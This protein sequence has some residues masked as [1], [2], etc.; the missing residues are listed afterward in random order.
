M[1]FQSNNSLVGL[2]NERD[3]DIL[4][5][6]VGRTVEAHA[7]L[8][9]A[10]EVL[11]VERASAV[12]AGP[13]L[14]ICH[15]EIGDAFE[16]RRLRRFAADVGGNAVFSSICEGDLASALVDALDTFGEACQGFPPI[17]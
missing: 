5:D 12:I 4:L 2:E 11:M 9:G 17:P 1:V 6:F 8:E 14:G 3:T 10:S 16:G 7:V 13:G 15:S